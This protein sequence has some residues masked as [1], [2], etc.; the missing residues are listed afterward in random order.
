MT[1][2]TARQLLPL[3]DRR[4]WNRPHLMY[5]PSALYRLYKDVRKRI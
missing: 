1:L 2:L 3:A 5:L 4:D